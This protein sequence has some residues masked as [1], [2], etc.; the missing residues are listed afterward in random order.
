MRPRP[1]N[2]TLQRLLDEHGP[3]PP[4]ALA[5]GTWLRRHLEPLAA[6]RAGE[7]LD[8]RE[9]AAGRLPDA[10]G[11]LLTGAG[12]EQATHQEVA[13]ARATRVAERMRDQLGPDA[14]V[15]DATCGLGGEAAALAREGVRVV[16]ADL[17]PTTAACARHNL[18]RWRPGSTEARGW[19]G[20]GPWVV[21]ADALAPPL[22][23]LG[24]RPGPPAVL[25]ADPS[26]RPDGQRT[27]RPAD[28]SPSWPALAAVLGRFAGAVV[29]LAPA[30]RPEEL[31]SYLPADLARHWVWVS[32]RG[33]LAE[34][35]LFTGVLASEP[36]REPGREACLLSRT[37]PGR[38]LERLLGP[39]ERALDAR[40]LDDPSTAA[41]IGVPDPSLVTSGLLGPVA[42]AAG[43]A[44]LGSGIAFTGGAAPATTAALRSLRVLGTAKL[45]R[46]AVRRLLAEH[47]VGPVRVL[48]RG[49]NESAGELERRL[50]GPGAERGLLVV[51]RCDS[52]RR[53]WLVEEAPQSPPG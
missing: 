34:L 43:H 39:P 12:L 27:L 13:A 41:F 22:A 38:V 7:L 26:R 50:A 17:D 24:D 3:P 32:R 48:A 5:R 52:G 28:W 37:E 21:V 20:D 19:S 44:P 2:E 31:G 9:R 40:P 35:V 51:A 4:D 1:E 45:D 29:K 53:V 25:L 49:L 11:L 33:E 16:A 6:A 18:E 8:L 36:G 42:A 30:A 10:D 15:L 46:R 23:A 47:G 14:L